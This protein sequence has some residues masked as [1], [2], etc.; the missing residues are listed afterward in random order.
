MKANDV[1]RKTN[2]LEFDKETEL[3][4]VKA[5]FNQQKA[6]IKDQIKENE[7]KF[8]EE[9]YPSKKAEKDIKAK[10][11]DLQKKKEDDLLHAKLIFFFKYDYYY[12]LI[13]DDITNKIIQ[14]LGNRVFTK[15]FRIEVPHNGFE[16]QEGTMEFKV[17]A[18]IN[19]GDVK[20]YKCVGEAYGEKVTVYLN[21]E[22]E[23]ALG[24][25][26]YLRPKL[27][28]T[29]IYEDDLNIRLY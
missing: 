25:V 9:N 2:S 5:R 4:G 10:R 15:I 18:N 6:L 27:E 13:P 24:E 20:M 7:R 29:Q 21:K 3:N 8:Q 14:G 26:V 28:E 1:E 19:Y 17:V 12:Q 11:K 16:E 23:I 22:R